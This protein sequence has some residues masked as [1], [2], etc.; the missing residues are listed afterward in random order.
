MT[1]LPDPPDEILAAARARSAARA[2]R[3]WPRAD[4]L[5]A[6]IEAAGWK[7]E[8]A[9]TAFRLE[10][11]T[12]PT[13]EE[14]GVIR[15]GTSLAVPSVLDEPPTARFTV[16]LVAEDWPDD[17]ASMLAGLRA[18][19]PAGTQVVIVANA[20]SARRRRRGSPPEDRTWSRSPAR[21][22][23]WSGPA[24]A[25]AMRRPAMLGLR[26][27]AGSIV[28]LVDSSTEPTG[29]ALTPL[30]AALAEPAVAVAGG[31]GLVSA[32]FRH[33]SD[34]ADPSVDAIGISWLAFRRDDFACPGP[35]RREARARRRAWT[36]GG[37]WS[38]G[39]ETP[40]RHRREQARRLDLPLVRHLAR[41][42]G[43]PPPPQRDRLEKRELLPPARP[44]PRSPRPPLRGAHRSARHR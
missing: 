40:R 28:V 11:A 27:A 34:A 25:W 20:P 3:D 7:V 21:R 32:D 1:R 31:F 16:E 8:D 37:A 15:Y 24:R 41:V 23:R 6:E 36:S 2:A 44:L 5:R 9:G 42:P 39:R 13:V 30:E 17:L 22:P 43:G 35:A 26:R 12:P 18:H 38:S 4:A 33:F 10:P 14:A 29:D 19:A